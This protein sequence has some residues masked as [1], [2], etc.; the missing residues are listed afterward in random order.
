MG[1][2]IQMLLP[3]CVLN[4]NLILSLKC[5]WL[6]LLTCINPDVTF[7][8]KA[9]EKPVKYH[10]V[11]VALKWLYALV[12]KF[13]GT[14]PREDRVRQEIKNL[15]LGDTSE[16][17]QFFNKHP[18]G[19]KISHAAG[20]GVEVTQISCVAVKRAAFPTESWTIFAEGMTITCSGQIHLTV[21]DVFHRGLLAIF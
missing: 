17:K 1:C 14:T 15:D 10:G 2:I 13:G 9:T 16:K 3:S 7:K 21:C 11:A 4:V 6:Q 19:T 8:S 20:H 18:N 12:G 5:V